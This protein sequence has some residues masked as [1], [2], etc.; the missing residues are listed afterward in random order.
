MPSPWI[1]RTDWKES[2]GL[3]MMQLSYR[4]Y[5]HSKFLETD[6]FCEMGETQICPWNQGHLSMSSSSHFFLLGQKSSKHSTL[7]QPVK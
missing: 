3:N 5:N 7:Q 2:R 1:F 4:S 6:A